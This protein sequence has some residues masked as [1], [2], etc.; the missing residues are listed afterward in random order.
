[1][2]LEP[3]GMRILSLILAAGA[4][5]AALAAPATGRANVAAEARLARA[6][7]G[8]VAG[9]PVNCIN[10]RDIRTSEI[11]DRT[12]ILYRTNGNKLYV[13][14]PTMGG[15]SLDR[16][17]TMVIATQLPQLCNVDVVRLVDPTI[18]MQTGVVGLGSFVPYTKSE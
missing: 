6:L 1:M 7:E 8:R 16:F 18:G 5:S 2:I 10:L 15:E 9:A 4:L 3:I 17:D 13:N 12:A 14:R 11:F